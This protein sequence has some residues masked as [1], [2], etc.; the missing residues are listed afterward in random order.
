MIRI[1]CF[2]IIFMYGKT[3]ITIDAYLIKD[4]PRE[5]LKKYNLN[6]Y[7]W[8]KNNFLNN[9]QNKNTSLDQC[10][11]EWIETDYGSIAYYTPSKFIRPFMLV[12]EKKENTEGEWFII[13]L[14]KKPL[15]C[16]SGAT[17]AK[18][19]IDGNIVSKYFWEILPEG[20]KSTY[21]NNIMYE[22]MNQ[23]CFIWKFDDVSE[24][25]SF[26]FN[27]RSYSNLSRVS[28]QKSEVIYF[29]K[30]FDVNILAG[31]DKDKFSK[32]KYEWRVL[33]NGISYED[34]KNYKI[35]MP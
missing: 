10:F 25:E 14:S 22:K 30:A 16:L 7:H 3:G 21:D 18:W 23:N 4:P 12:Y 1:I 8:I 11:S 34:R 32:L 15:S 6:F 28:S 31:L 33:L 26:H 17:G 24:N 20:C 13:L 29:F 27:F 9:L 2:L 5:Y 19:S 35:F